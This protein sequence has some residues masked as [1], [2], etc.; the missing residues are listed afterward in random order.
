MDKY[1][2]K[3]E[4]IV[5]SS[6]SIAPKEFRAFI[7]QN[8]EPR[9]NLKHKDY[10]DFVTKYSDISIGDADIPST[11]KGYV[12]FAFYPIEDTFELNEP[13]EEEFFLIAESEEEYQGKNENLSFYLSLSND[14]QN[15]IYY[16]IYNEDEKMKY[17]YLCE[18]FTDFLELAINNKGRLMNKVINNKF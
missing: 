6:I 15:G 9:F 7:H 1:I 11:N 18:R 5:P 12:F 13:F 17:Q 4:K 10:L 14:R 16:S 2:E 3:F 8:I